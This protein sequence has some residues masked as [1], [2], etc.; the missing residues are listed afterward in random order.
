MERSRERI[1]ELHDDDP[2][3][4]ARLLQFVY[5]DDYEGTIIEDR[6]TVVE[7]HLT[8]EKLIL[9]GKNDSRFVDP[10][11][12]EAPDNHLF[13]S[14]EVYEIADKYRCLDLQDLTRSNIGKEGVVMNIINLTTMLNY[15]DTEYCKE[16]INKDQKLRADFCS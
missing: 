14:F 16:I 15:R 10:I 11:W 9:T 6:S 4:F 7:K 3:I 5:C 13:L 2:A 12:F 1:V 8:L